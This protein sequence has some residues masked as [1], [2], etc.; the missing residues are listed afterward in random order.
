MHGH[1][2]AC[3]ATSSS[4]TEDVVEDAGEGCGGTAAVPPSITTT[5]S[6]TRDLAVLSAWAVEREQHKMRVAR[7]LSF[8]GVGNMEARRALRAG[9]VLVNGKALTK[10]SFFVKKGQL[11]QLLE[12]PQEADLLSSEE[13]ATRLL[14]EDEA[15]LAVDKPPGFTS[16]PSNGDGGRS[17]LAQLEVWLAGRDG[18]PTRLM[19]LHRLDKN[20]SGCL[21]L[22]KQARVNARVAAQFRSRKVKKKYFAVMS[23]ELSGLSHRW[24]DVLEVREGKTRVLERDV[25]WREGSG[26]AEGMS[27]SSVVVGDT[28]VRVVEVFAAAKA[29]AVEFTPH[30][31]RTHQLRVQA[32]ARGHPLLG[33]EIYGP[34]QTQS[35]RGSHLAVPRLALHCS[36]LSVAHPLR[37]GTVVELAAPLPHDI[38]STVCRLRE[39]VSGGGR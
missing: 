35:G 2:C 20:T 25:G 28:E 9:R 19:P 12:P 10:G 26:S 33:D 4:L 21:L 30:T 8:Q 14:Y 36:A 38:R 27:G 39:Y 22:S 37:V 24:S 7:F 3:Q 5:R 23:G 29:T 11:V 6:G 15:L 34:P 17:V 18:S 16:T 32:E 13:W 1:G 31:G